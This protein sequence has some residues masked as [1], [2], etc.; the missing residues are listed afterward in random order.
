MPW[1][2]EYA[3]SAVK[4]LL[5]MDWQ[6]ARRIKKYL[7]ERVALSEDP[8]A[9]GHGLQSNLAGLWRYRVGDWRVIAEIQ[10]AR[11]VILVVK[12]GP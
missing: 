1:T 8:R 9:F 5:S 3:E 2:I 12:A 7:E 4:E 6:Q 11:L 10:D